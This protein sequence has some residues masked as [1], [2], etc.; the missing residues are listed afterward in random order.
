VLDALAV[1]VPVVSY[2]RGCIGEILD[3]SGGIVFAKGSKMSNSVVN[4]LETILD[5]QS[6]FKER[7]VKSYQKFRK[8]KNEGYDSLK[9]METMLNTD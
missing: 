4:D 5:S 8:L 2:E 3:G 1:G 7:M 6:D 9:L